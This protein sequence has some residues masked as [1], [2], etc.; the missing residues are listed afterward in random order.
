MKEMDELRGRHARDLE[1]AK[2][3]LSDIYEQRVA[4]LKDCKDELDGRVLKLEQQLKD[5]I[6]S[7]CLKGRVSS[8]M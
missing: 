1:M 7:L 2:T 8:M 5:K 4:H 6:V 3:T